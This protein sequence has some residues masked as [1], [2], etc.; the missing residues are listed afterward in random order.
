VE[1]TIMR[2]LPSLAFASLLLLPGAALACDESEDDE[3][4]VPAD[5]FETRLVV[6]E[7]AWLDSELD[8]T[9][10]E[11]E[12]GL[13]LLRLRRPTGAWVAETWYFRLV[14]DPTRARTFEEMEQLEAEHR[15]DD[16]SPGGLVIDQVLIY[17][18]DAAQ[19]GSLALAMRPRTLPARVQEAVRDSGSAQTIEPGGL[20]P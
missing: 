7:G 9:W 17:A 13:F 6:R 18:S 1:V 5:P 14:S 2:T 12:P 15:L 19:A 3:A 11:L 8:S 16:T 20:V 10:S 4:D